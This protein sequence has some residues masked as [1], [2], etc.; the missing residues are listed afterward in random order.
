[1]PAAAT[2]PASLRTITNPPDELFPSSLPA[3]SGA[4]AVPG[5]PHVFPISRLSFGHP[6][7]RLLDSFLPSLVPLRVGNPLDV[8]PLMAGRERIERSQRVL[9]AL[10]S[11]QEV[12]WNLNGRFRRLRRPRHLHPRLVQSGS[13]LHELEEC[14]L[15]RQV[16]E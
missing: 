7:H 11:A 13:V 14:A 9:V 6:R 10:Q 15:L 12:T 2:S 3:F 8:L 16:R 1:M 5:S 4:S